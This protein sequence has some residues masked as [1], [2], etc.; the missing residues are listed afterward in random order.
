MEPGHTPS[1]ATGG[2]LGIYTDG[3][4]TA[5][6]T[7]PGGT[8]R[9]GLGAAYY[10]S[11]SSIQTGR[12]LVT[13]SVE[14]YD[15]VFDAMGGTVSEAA[16]LT[17][18]GLYQVP[19]LTQITPVRDNYIFRGWYVNQACTEAAVSVSVSAASPPPQPVRIAPHKAI[20]EIDI[21]NFFAKL[22][23]PFC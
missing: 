6:V 22:I 2:G 18:A 13:I 3:N 9:G 23:N 7:V 16:I 11:G 1:K 8:T 21:K 20:A 4:Y 19:D 15:V 10:V 12:P 5:T 14:K 17:K